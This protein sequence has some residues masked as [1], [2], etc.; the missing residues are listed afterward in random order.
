MT[1]RFIFLIFSLMTII[2]AINA[3]VVTY[4]AGEG[5]NLLEDYTV[6]VRQKGGEWQPI[7]VYPVKVDEVAN[8]K[9]TVKIASMAYFDFDG[10]VEVEVTYNKGPVE[11]ARIRPLSYGIN[12][13]VAGNKVT[14]KLDRPRN[15]SIEVNDDIFH[16]L[17][18]FANPIDEY[19]L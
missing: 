11:Q 1:R 12:A 8:T 6:N 5:V 4:P 14:F 7:D 16:N 10:I 2:S 17:H 3:K 18:L 19:C 15:L 13:N 9:H